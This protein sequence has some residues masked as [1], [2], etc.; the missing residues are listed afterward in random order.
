MHDMTGV[1]MIAAERNRQITQEGWTAEHDDGHKHGEMAVAADA[2]IFAALANVTKVKVMKTILWPWK[3]EDWKPSHTDPVRNLVK[4]GALI[5]AEI[6]RLQRG[7][8]YTPCT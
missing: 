3:D 2:Y 5:A 7:K 6:D 8:G 1:D 4:A